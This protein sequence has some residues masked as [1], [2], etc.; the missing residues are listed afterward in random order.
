MLNIFILNVLNTGKPT[1][2][3][4]SAQYLQDVADNISKEVKNFLLNYSLS[5]TIYSGGSLGPPTTGIGSF[6]T[7]NE[8]LMSIHFKQGLDG[9]KDENMNK[10]IAVG[11]INGLST[12]CKAPGTISEP[13]VAGVNPSSSPVV[14]SGIGT[15]VDVPIE[16]D[17]MI[18][19]FR[20][21]SI[22]DPNDITP[23]QTMEQQRL[24]MFAN[25]LA[26]GV[27]D[28]INVPIAINMTGSTGE[29]G[30]GTIKLIVPT[31]TDT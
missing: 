26:K 28:Y 15:V 20:N 4:N 10:S 9:L 12:M 30:I 16:P 22:V 5:G 31:V 29:I 19:A 3:A 24:K 25:V 14:F 18:E 1:D 23:T 8:S 7:L 6:K 27:E 17:E 13:T 2:P 11:F 21:M